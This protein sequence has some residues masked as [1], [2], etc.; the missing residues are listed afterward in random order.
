M[1]Q[2]IVEKN[3]PVNNNAYFNNVNFYINNLSNSQVVDGEYDAEKRKAQ[4]KEQYQEIQR[5]SRCDTVDAQV[6][7]IIDGEV[8]AFI[9]GKY[10]AEKTAEIIQDKVILYLNE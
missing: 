7:N 4:V 5:I 9:D 10:T 6:Y 3:I 1:K 8:K 2:I